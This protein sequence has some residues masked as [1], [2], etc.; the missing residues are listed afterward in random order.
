MSII[1]DLSS[2]K[3]AAFNP[4]VRRESVLSLLHQDRYWITDTGSKTRL[5][6]MTPRH[7]A[8][9]RD[10]LNRNRKRIY[11]SVVDDFVFGMRPRGDAA[12]DAF[13]SA[14]DVLMETT[15]KQWLMESPLY[16]K[17]IQLVWNDRHER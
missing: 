17:L 16:R 6:Y 8:N 15:P 10:W 14:F 4:N 5:D 12:Q 7:R 1:L 9:L 13:E 11:D 2:V 3:S